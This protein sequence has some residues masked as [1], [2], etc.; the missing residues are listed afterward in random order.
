M[1]SKNYIEDYLRFLNEEGYKPEID[2]EFGIV[3]QFKGDKY[4]LEFFNNPNDHQNN[5]NDHQLFSI[6][7]GKL[8]NF[9][10]DG[11]KITALVLANEINKSSWMGKLWV[12]LEAGS[13]DA[14]VSYYLDDNKIF[15]NNFHECCKIVWGVFKTFEQ[16]WYNR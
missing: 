9:K 10:T 16:R 15:K 14:L 3:F 2:E 13:V 7:T 5:P 1:E 12:D 11:D 6:G 8:L 4:A